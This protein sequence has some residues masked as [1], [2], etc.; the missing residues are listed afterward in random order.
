MNLGSIS[1]PCTSFP[2]FFS[3]LKE[4]NEFFHWKENCFLQVFRNT[5]YKWTYLSFLLFAYSSI[6][7]WL[8]LRNNE[9]PRALKPKSQNIRIAVGLACLQAFFKYGKFEIGKLRSLMHFLNKCR[10][11]LKLSHFL[12]DHEQEKEEFIEYG[13]LSSDRKNWRQWLF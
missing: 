10:A 4:K 7:Q 5:Y 12:P 6:C 2:R 3:S 13:C 11:F 8:Y 9:C 1:S